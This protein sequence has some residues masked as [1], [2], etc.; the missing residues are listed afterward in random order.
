MNQSNESAVSAVSLAFVGV[1]VG[2]ILMLAGTPNLKALIVAAHLGPSETTQAAS[3]PGQGEGGQTQKGQSRGPV[4]L[5][6]RMAEIDQRFQQA[7]AM[8]HARRFDDAAM[9]LHR[10]ILLSPRL[11]EAYVNMGYAMIG[12]E[13]YDAARDFFLTATDLRPY[14]ANAY[15]G[16]AIAFEQMN[17]LEGA[18]GA[19]RTFIHLSPPGDPY[20]RKARSA[21]WEWNTRLARGPLPENE[22]Q[23]IEARTRQWEDRNLPDR[24]A[25]ETGDLAIPVRNLQ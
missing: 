2:A 24:D 19:M 17:D 15:Y 14:Q 4:P 21:L 9:A 1:I 11:A 7:V 20:V 25:R 6:P 10:V 18:L 5:D 12:L 23:W 22:A 3:E 16:L 8:L 13:R